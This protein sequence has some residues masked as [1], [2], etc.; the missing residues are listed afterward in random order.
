MARVICKGNLANT[1]QVVGAVRGLRLALCL[2]GALVASVG[3]LLLGAPTILLSLYGSGYSVWSAAAVTLLLQELE[4]FSS[5]E[6][7]RKNGKIR[8]FV[9]FKTFSNITIIL[10]EMNYTFWHK[11]RM[12]RV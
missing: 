2:S 5:F 6:I 1:S 3:F 4:F 12:S 8:T 7:P 11:F 9:K 10:V